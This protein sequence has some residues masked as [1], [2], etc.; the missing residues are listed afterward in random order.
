M[1]LRWWEMLQNL[2]KDSPLG[3]SMAWYSSQSLYCSVS[4]RILIR[5][6]LDPRLLSS[7]EGAHRHQKKPES[8]RC[9]TSAE[10]Q[11]RASVPWER[12]AHP[13]AESLPEG[14][15]RQGEDSIVASPEVSQMRW[16]VKKD[17]CVPAGLMDKASHR[18][19]HSTSGTSRHL[20]GPGWGANTYNK[21]GTQ[22]LH[23]ND[24]VP[25][26]GY[27]AQCKAHQSLRT[28]TQFLRTHHI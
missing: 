13:R 12:R 2:G 3:I 24:N 14:W 25:T 8:K 26:S 5:I 23:L 4:P 15:T 17:R 18:K 7:E 28:I 20:G 11:V 27:R 21:Q 22:S 16:Q 6:V 10:P 19:Q 1:T 9:K